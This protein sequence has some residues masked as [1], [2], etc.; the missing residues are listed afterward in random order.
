MRLFIVIA[1]LVAGAAAPSFADTP[2]N[3]QAAFVERRGL[4]EI[5]ARCHLLSENVRGALGAGALQARGALLRS[6][7][8][9]ARAAELERA[10][11]TAARA[12]ACADPRNAVAVSQ[13]QAGYASWART[14]AMIFTGAER[15]WAA[16]RY[17]DADG[18]RLV[19][20]IETPRGARFG[21][22]V[23]NGDERIT[24]IVPLARGARPPGGA[25][26]IVRDPSRAGVQAL[27]LPGRRARGLAGAAPAPSASRSF[28]ANSRRSETFADERLYGVLTFPASAFAPLLALDPREA[29]VLRL[30][31]GAV[32]QNI[33]VEVGDLAVARTFLT[34]TPES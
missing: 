9:I 10:T 1:C 3:A 26:L 25:Q 29:V 14:P 5:D 22:R 20:N 4:I 2:P 16:R 23:I 27:E 7:W 17:P 21:V 15:A 11:A 13:A 28:F 8:T 18:W 31:T 6:G 30:E 32:A 34:L 33:Y 12:R 24:L 19:Q